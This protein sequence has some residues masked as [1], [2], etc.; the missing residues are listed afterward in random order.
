MFLD[1]VVAD[2][3]DEDLSKAEWMLVAPVTTPNPT[4]TMNIRLCNAL[5]PTAFPKIGDERRNN[6]LTFIF[7]D[8]TDGRM[9]D[10]SNIPQY[11]V[12]NGQYSTVAIEGWLDHSDPSRLEDL[13]GK[14]LAKAWYP[15]A[16][17]FYF[18]A[19]T[20][21]QLNEAILAIRYLRYKPWPVLD[22]QRGT[23][24]FMIR[25]WLARDLD[26][27]GT[28]IKNSSI[29]EKH[30][31][32]WDPSLLQNNKNVE[33]KLLSR[34]D[35]EVYGLDRYG[36][37]A[38]SVDLSSVLGFSPARQGEWITQIP[39]D[40]YGDFIDGADIALKRV[41]IS[42]TGDKLKEPVIARVTDTSI[43]IVNLPNVLD[44]V[45][46]TILYKENG[47]ETWR[48]HWDVRRD[49]NDIGVFNAATIS[50]LK[51]NTAYQVEVWVATPEERVIYGE[52]LLPWFYSGNPK[53][54]VDGIETP[55]P[56][57]TTII[58]TRPNRLD[59]WYRPIDY[60]IEPGIFGVVRADRAADITGSKYIKIMTNLGINNVDPH[61][62]AFRNVLAVVPCASDN[63][64]LIS[65]FSSGAS[66]EFPLRSSKLDKVQIWLEDDKG[67]PMGMHNDWMIELGVRMDEPET[68]DVY[69]GI[70]DYTGAAVDFHAAGDPGRYKRL[71]D[72]TNIIYQ[73]LDHEERENTVKRNQRVRRR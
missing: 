58:T 49:E 73:V 29:V 2:Q 10:V 68:V 37:T 34:R 65:W 23:F 36:I 71:Y 24:C 12:A 48:V 44:R 64:D 45:T 53:V 15:N 1:T 30:G 40:P 50:G 18:A 4:Y 19:H 69:K 5:L 25:D 9:D 67:N 47:T 61:T 52:L 14:A 35:V 17:N 46:G 63:S 39:G 72:E 11:C 16:A 33:F 7:Y 43:T 26:T 42:D 54:I 31:D 62:K 22:K 8:S 51:P 32:Q 66:V 38:E 57:Q 6:K 41:P 59:V 70:H 55:A 56:V 13:L 3:K 60:N 28:E 20:D 21:E 27:D